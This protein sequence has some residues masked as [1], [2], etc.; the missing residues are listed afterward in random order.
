MR[1]HLLALIPF[2]RKVKYSDVE[3]EFGKEV[4]NLVRVADRTSLPNEPAS[5]GRNPWEDLITLAEVRPRSAITSAWHRVQEAALQAADDRKLEITDAAKTMPMVVG[6]ILL[7][8]GVIS[9]SQ[10]ELLSKLRSLVAD[11]EHA[12]RGALSPE[13]AIEFIGLALRLAASI[14]PHATEARG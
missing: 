9:H 8:E 12:T 10:Y 14:N 2:V 11:A 1:K 7:N 13:N 5:G 4:A 3:I 6:S